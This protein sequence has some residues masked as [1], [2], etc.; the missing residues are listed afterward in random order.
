MTLRRVAVQDVS[1]IYCSEALVMKCHNRLLN[2]HLV[3]SSEQKK[4]CP[5]VMNTKFKGTKLAEKILIKRK[6]NIVQLFNFITI[7]YSK[8]A[9]V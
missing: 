9:K 8:F 2:D 6:K 4:I 7:T 5:Q 1:S 3:K